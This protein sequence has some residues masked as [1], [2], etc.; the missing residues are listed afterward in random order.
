M[1]KMGFLFLGI[2]V[3]IVI[4][5]LQNAEGV[6][7]HAKRIIREVASDLGDVLV[8]VYQEIRSFSTEIE[9]L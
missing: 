6:A 5:S 4:L 1:K 3:V 9:G 7:S 2:V 8:E